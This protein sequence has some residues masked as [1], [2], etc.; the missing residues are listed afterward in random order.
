MAIIYTRD[1]TLFGLRM[2]QKQRE[3]ENLRLKN[4]G[5]ES[6]EWKHHIDNLYQISHVGDSQL[7]ETVAH[8]GWFTF[9]CP[10]GGGCCCAGSGCF[11]SCSTGHCFESYCRTGCCCFAWGFLLGDRC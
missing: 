7:Q 8:T 11:R 2:R 4:D 3:N 9:S 5:G 1:A 6:K 10:S